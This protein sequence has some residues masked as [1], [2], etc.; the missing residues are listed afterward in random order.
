ML[1][2]FRLS[3][4]ADETDSSTLCHFDLGLHMETALNKTGAS[5]KAL[6]GWRSFKQYL[7]SFLTG[8][9]KYKAGQYWSNLS[10]LHKADYWPDMPHGAKI[11]LAQAE[12]PHVSSVAGTGAIVVID[13]GPQG[14]R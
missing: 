10:F 9:E 4:A 5:D 3:L 8:R 7:W 13:L 11:S 6:Y 1:I 12:T 2:D 14:S